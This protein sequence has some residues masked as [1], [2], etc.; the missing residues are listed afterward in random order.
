MDAEKEAQMTLTDMRI[1][2]VADN[3]E[4]IASLTSE[5]VCNLGA[6]VTIVNSVEEARAFAGPDKFDVILAAEK[7][8]DGGG[9]ELI[10]EESPLFDAPVIL[11]DG[12][13]D[14]QRILKAL[15]NGVADVIPQPIDA[16]HLV[17]TVRKAVELHRLRKHTVARTF[18]LR[19]M[20]S[21]LVRDRRELRQ[22]VDLICRDLVCAYRRL[23]QKVVGLRHPEFADDD[24]PQMDSRESYDSQN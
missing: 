13:L 7:L 19:R 16:N 15:R 18:R 17:A 11:L 9:L 8:P 12:T 20:S 10:D 14:A 6:N 24:E 5:V 22:R 3:A 21:K 1:L 2:I 23:A 4:L